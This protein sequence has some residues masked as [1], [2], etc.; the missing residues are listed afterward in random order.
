VE[1]KRTDKIKLAVYYELPPLTEDIYRLSWAL[2]IKNDQ[3]P[4]Y[5]NLQLRDIPQQQVKESIFSQMILCALTQIIVC[6]LLLNYMSKQEVCQPSPWPIEMIRFALAFLIHFD[7]AREVDVCLA[8]LKYQAYHYDK[9]EYPSIAFLTCI[10]Q[11]TAVLFV[12]CLNIYNSQFTC[13]V[14]DLVMNYVALKCISQFD[15]YMAKAYSHLNQI[16][17]EPAYKIENFR[18]DRY[19]ITEKGEE[20]F[21]EID[22]HLKTRLN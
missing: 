10:F 4:N 7:F 12:E 15:D 19:V 16:Y 11:L 2:S 8:C 9:F 1:D 14:I 3:L 13:T 20:A 18:T 6:L 17:I 22:R 5:E 21:K